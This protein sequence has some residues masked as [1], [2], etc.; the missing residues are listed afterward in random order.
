[1]RTIARAALA[2]LLLLPACSRRNRDVGIHPVAFSWTTVQG[3]LRRAGAEREPLPTDPATAWTVS[4]GRGLK[5]E[6]LVREGVLL[7]A[8]SNRLVA[9]YSAASGERFWERRLNASVSGGI[10]WR[11]DT[12]WLATESLSGEAT[13]LRLGKGDDLWEQDVGPASLPPLLL[14]PRL[15]L[16]TDDGSLSALDAATGQ[17]AWRT[18]LPGGVGS[19]P[20]PYKGTIVT[21]GARDT[22]YVMESANGDI[23]GRIA[24]PAGASALPALQGD[25][26][27]VP[28]RGG[29]LVAIDL[30]LGEVRWRTRVGAEVMATPV[31]AE[32]GSI[33]CLT[34]SAEVWRVAP[35]ERSA[36]RIADLGGT[37]RASLTLVR[38]GLL[39]GRLDG[40]LFYLDR[41]GHERWRRAL[42][43]SIFAPVAV[44][45]RAIFVPLLDGRLSKLE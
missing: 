40:T 19:T 33:Y 15:Y 11:S 45:E 27:V 10:V 23:T 36:T 14:G 34:T 18:R 5:S 42:G 21:V 20:V 4:I 16:A 32:D 13:A 29:E 7:V 37:A 43:G 44:A 28:V 35:G 6:P 17:R 24:M 41:T 2:L 26:L 12:L 22:I 8:G 30:E 31:I 3:D 38:D 39:V 9:A 1:M 25:L